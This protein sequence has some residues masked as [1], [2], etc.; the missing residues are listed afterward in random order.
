[1]AARS[2]RDRCYDVIRSIPKGR[3]MTYGDVAFAIGKPGAARA[4]GTAMRLNPDAPRTPC[5]RVVPSTGVLG[6][7]SG[8]RGPVRKKEL[9]R[10]EGV[11]V[12][13]N[14]RIANFEEVRWTPL[15]N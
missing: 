8:P 11:S 13:S 7:Y 3:V 6:E 12:R 15:R 14:G 2:F 1:M 5:H 9:L 10:R 4:V